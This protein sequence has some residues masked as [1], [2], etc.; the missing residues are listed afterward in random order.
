MVVID[1]LGKLD[2]VPF[3]GGAA[4]DAEL[5][6]GSGQSIPG[7]EEQAGRCQAGGATTQVKVTFLENYQSEELKGVQPPSSRSR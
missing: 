4:E 5:V 3:D 2:G 7:F 1:F 6:L